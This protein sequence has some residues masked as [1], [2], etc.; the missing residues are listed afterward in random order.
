MFEKLLKEQLRKYLSSNTIINDVQHG[1]QQNHSCQT[2]LLQLSKTLFTLKSPFIT[3]LDL[4]RAFNTISHEI[5]YKILCTFI[6]IATTQW[7]RS[8]LFRWNQSTRY[9]DTLSDK[10][11][12]DTFSDKRHLSSGMLQGSILGPTLF[13][14]YIN[15]LAIFGPGNIIV[16]ADDISIISSRTMPMEAKASAE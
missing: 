12:C 6:D 5:L 3:A 13:T 4:S 2:A 14:L 7:F 15:P 1:F 8:Y 16:Y 9:C 10:R 11:Y